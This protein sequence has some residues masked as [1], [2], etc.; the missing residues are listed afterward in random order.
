MPQRAERR[1][2][3]LAPGGHTTAA[4]PAAG[5]SDAAGKGRIVT[6]GRDVVA[7][8]DLIAGSRR[9][10]RHRAGIS[11]DSGIPYFPWAAGGLDPQPRPRSSPPSATISRMPRC[12]V[13]PGRPG[14]DSPIWAAQPTRGGNGARRAQRQ[15]E[16]DAIVTQNIDGLHQSPVATPARDRDRRDRHQT[17]CWSCGHPTPTPEVPE[18]VL[19]RRGRPAPPRARRRGIG[20]AMWRDP[21]SATISFGQNL[22]PEVLARSEEAALAADLLLAVGRPSRLP[23]GRPRPARERRRRRR[24]HRQR[25]ANRPLSSS[26][27]RPARPDPGSCCR[28]SSPGD[29]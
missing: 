13:S 10:S 4:L 12:G 23:G 25:G 15:G 5:R 26:L 22:D 8:R 21:Q 6:E 20:R 19:W 16:A 1:V 29:P 3:G 27:P 18:R 24:R 7:A 28:P 11:T 14:L 9:S 17:V 2:A